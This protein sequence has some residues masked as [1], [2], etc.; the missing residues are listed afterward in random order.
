MTRLQHKK[1]EI[2][3]EVGWWGSKKKPCGKKT[4]RGTRT[5]GPGRRKCAEGETG[6]WIPP[7]IS[8]PEGLMSKGE[9]E[10]AVA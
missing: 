5:T 3:S 10:G 2:R 4:E 7:K 8:D 6:P 1:I 9:S